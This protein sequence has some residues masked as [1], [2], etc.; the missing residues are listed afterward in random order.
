MT[1]ERSEER[2]W[3]DEKWSKKGKIKSDVRM[4]TILEPEK[5][6]WGEA[7]RLVG[8][9][10]DYRIPRKMMRREED[11]PAIDEDGAI[12]PEEWEKQA[13]YLRKQDQIKEI[14][15]KRQDNEE[16][17]EE[18]D[19]IED[20]LGSED[21]AEEKRD[22]NY[23]VNKHC[24]NK[25]STYTR[26]CHY[27]S[28]RLKTKVNAREQYDKIN[29][30]LMKLEKLGKEQRRCYVCNRTGHLAA[31]CWTQKEKRTCF[32]CQKKGT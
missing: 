32:K 5:L 31:R 25:V 14:A 4:T 10:G 8:D 9:W 18:F 7:N 20:L 2:W 24:M 30:G 21:E 12:T 11:A 27:C 15:E 29:K 16:K 23:C 1:R 26:V 28:C 19:S 17:E 22:D 6:P 3:L 13:A